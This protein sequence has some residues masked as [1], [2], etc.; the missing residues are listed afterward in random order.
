ME[1]IVKLAESVGY[2]KFNIQWFENNKID[3]NTWFLECCLLQK[4]IREV[5]NIHIEI[6]Y[7]GI[8]Y[9]D[10]HFTYRSIIKD[11]NGKTIKETINPI[12]SEGFIFRSYEEILEISLLESLKLLINKL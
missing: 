9:E 8:H 5:H 2:N 12:K 11:I 10:K 6:F 7:I 4:W 1:E 3:P